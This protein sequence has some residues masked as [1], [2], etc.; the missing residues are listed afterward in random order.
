MKYSIC[1]TSGLGNMILS[2]TG[3]YHILMSNNINPYQNGEILEWQDKPY[4]NGLIFGGHP[5]ANQRNLGDI[6]SRINYKNIKKSLED[7]D[8]ALTIQFCNDGYNAYELSQIVQDISDD[9]TKYIV[10]TGW[11]F[12]NSYRSL[13]RDEIIDWLEFGEN[14]QKEVNDFFR[15]NNLIPET[16]I[17]FHCRLGSSG[18]Y[19]SLDYLTH[20]EFVKGVKYI[21]EKYP[22]MTSILVCS[23]N[24]ERFENKYNPQELMSELG[25]R[26]VFYNS[27]IENCLHAMIK[28][29][30]HML[31]YSTLSFCVL[32][33]DKKYPL[34]TIIL[35][36]ELSYLS[37][38]I[39]QNDERNTMTPRNGL[40]YYSEI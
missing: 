9:L 27:D 29:A 34:H 15:D 6:F 37:T 35:S 32:Y 39:I 33:L 30:H 3:F 24:K 4:E 28:C 26:Y 1:L 8:V 12:N 7:E 14:V 31:S 36:T 13:F 25:M 20:E 22:E 16:T 23:E 21:K 5:R 38:K 2:L 19:H 17:S 11:F 40:I 18:D 10:L